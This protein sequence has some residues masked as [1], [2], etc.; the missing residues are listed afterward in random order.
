MIVPQ[1]CCKIN[2]HARVFFLIFASVKPL[3]HRRRSNQKA[4]K[5]KQ[6]FQSEKKRLKSQ[7]KFKTHDMT[8]F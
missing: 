1:I 8:C 6:N 5:K 2:K 4:F 3:F 7:V